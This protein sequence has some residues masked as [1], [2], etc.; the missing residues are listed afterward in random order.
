MQSITPNE[1]HSMLRIR[2]SLLTISLMLVSIATLRAETVDEIINKHLQAIGGADAWKKVSALRMTGTATA[3][4]SEIPITLTM[5]H[6][7]GFR[8]D[9]TLM[10]MSGYQFITPTEGWSFM[11]FGGQQKPEAMTADD[12]KEAADDLDLQPLID[13]KQKGSTVVLAGKEDVEGT[14]CYKI[15]LTSKRGNVK[16]Y[17]IDPT[18][19]YLIRSVD[20]IK[21]NGQEHDQTTDF[22]NFQKLPEGVTLPMT[23]VSPMGPVTMKKI[24]V[25][26]KIDESVFKK[27]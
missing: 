17:F 25:N 13:Y 23:I 15:M 6:E 16:T 3:Q 22:S 4:G 1:N 9:M 26:P 10:G 21:A 7:K 27:G 19:F 5:V 2:T 14:E 24:E 20:K 18:S 12:V 11:P 8:M